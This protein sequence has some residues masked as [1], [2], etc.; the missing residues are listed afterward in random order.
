MT[1][2][3]QTPIIA[4]DCNGVTTEFNFNFQVPYQADGV[5]PA[6]MVML[7]E[8]DDTPVVV[9]PSLYTVTGINEVNGGTVIYP[10]TGDPAPTGYTLII[11]RNVDYS[12]PNAFPN[13]SFYP[14]MVENGLDRLDMQIQQLALDSE[15]G[16]YT[17]IAPQ[18]G[19]LATYAALRAYS[20]A[21][22]PLAYVQGR[23]SAADGGQGWWQYD[24]S[25]TTSTDDGGTVLLSGSARWKR[26][27]NGPAFAEWW[28]AVGD[29]TTNDSAAWQAA[30]DTGLCIAGKAG[31]VYG[32]NLTLNLDAET[33]EPWIRDAN[34]VDI[35]PGSTTRKLMTANGCTRVRLENVTID[36]GDD[37]TAGQQNTAIT[38]QLVDTQVEL[39][40]LEIFGA[41]KGT[42]CEVDGCGGVIDRIYIHDILGGAADEPIATNDVIDGLWIK[43]CDGLK[44]IAPRLHRMLTLSEDDP[45]P[46]AI[47]TRGIS[48]S[49]PMGMLDIIAFDGQY[50]DQHIDISG[51]LNAANINILGGS[52]QYGR[53]FGV[54]C[55][56]TPKKVRV[57]DFHAYRIALTSFVV[58]DSGDDSVPVEDYSFDSIFD[59]CISE[60]AGY[61]RDIYPGPGLVAPSAFK[62]QSN[63]E[64]NPSYPRAHLF[65]NCRAICLGITG[66]S[67]F[68]DQTTEYTVGLTKVIGNVGPHRN[69][70]MGRCT[71]EAI[72]D[73]NLAFDGFLLPISEFQRA[74]N[75][76]IPN[77][78]ATYI[79]WNQ[80]SAEDGPGVG[81]GLKLLTSSTATPAVNTNSIAVKFDDVYDV[82]V[83]VEFK[84]GAQGAGFGNGYRLAELIVNGNVASSR[85]RSIVQAVQDESTFVQFPASV[86]LS[87]GDTLQVRLIHNQEETIGPSAEPINILANIMIKS[88]GTTIGEVW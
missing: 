4:A 2:P 52:A 72:D 48:V 88:Q 44:V 25:D 34:F 40:D 26:V 8:D 39:I 12:Q 1:L 56:N 28:G 65:N 73:P 69:R 11:A 21:T 67:G 31:R 82:V 38:V 32:I 70:L 78:V 50:I 63:N 15:W 14:R 62:I 18:F 5:T 83:E 7:Q 9:N 42:M 66:E 13:A 36:R 27:Y 24:P 81:D 16:D 30:I 57:K 37:G 84:L 49:G 23:T 61:D 55:A 3:V 33:Q 87:A 53:Y 10:T 17:P 46:L 35:N 68:S 22:Y 29:G 41:G 60:E 77:S 76:S 20:P 45:D 19:V 54:K 80:S 85:H 59:G 58:S 75:Q 64:T 47:W 51:D 6:V 79:T 86:K 74:S 43:G 71:V